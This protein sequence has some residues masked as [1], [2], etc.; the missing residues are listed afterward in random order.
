MEKFVMLSVKM[1]E[2]YSS[3]S[4]V[5]HKVVLAPKHYDL[6]QVK[7]SVKEQWRDHYL[8]KNAQ[9]MGYTSEL[10]VEVDE[11]YPENFSVTEEDCNSFENFVISNF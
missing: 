10:I 1:Y 4:E 5:I 8:K 9:F 7:K 2:T 11:I 3:P 6:E